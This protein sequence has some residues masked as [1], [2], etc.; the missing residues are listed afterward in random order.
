MEMDGWRLAPKAC[1]DRPLNALSLPA[2][3]FPPVEEVFGQAWHACGVCSLWQAAWKVAIFHA[4][5]LSLP[6][7]SASHSPL[8]LL[9][10]RT[11][12][13]MLLMLTL[14]VPA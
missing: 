4:S 7:P 9:W 13:C 6:L 8:P 3:L 10:G 14:P 1:W 11:N 2:H 12:V 5:E